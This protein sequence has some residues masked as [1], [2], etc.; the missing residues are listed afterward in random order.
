MGVCVVMGIDLKPQYPASSY[1]FQCL[2]S[3]GGDPVA[4]KVAAVSLITSSN[5]LEEISRALCNLSTALE[6]VSAT[7][8]A[9]LLRPLQDLQK[10][11]FPVTHGPGTRRY[12][13]F[14]ELMEAKNSSWYIADQSNLRDSFLGVLPLLAL[15]VEDLASIRELLKVLRLDDR[16][17]SKLAEKG[18]QARGRVSNHQPYTALLQERAPFIKA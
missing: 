16:V 5:G 14:D 3:P 10:G 17:L 1:L 4:A 15:P 6:D 2:A 11:I 13:K 7:K 18:V 9:Q 8:A 12:G